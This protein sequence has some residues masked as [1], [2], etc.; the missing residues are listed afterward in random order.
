MRRLCLLI[1]LFLFA[2]CGDHP[3][4]GDWNQSM[5]GG[6]KGITLQFNTENDQCGLHGAPRE[7]GGHRHASGTYTYDEAG[8][9]VTVNIELLTQEG[10]GS[11]TGTLV[12]GKLSLSSAEGKLVEF[13]LGD[14]PH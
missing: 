11:W 7:D 4:K 13:E 8:G 12:D 2:A 1:P 14:A 3:L 5:A 10:E 6:T 9:A